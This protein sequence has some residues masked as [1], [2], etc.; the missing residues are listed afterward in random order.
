MGLVISLAVIIVLFMASLFQSTN[1]LDQTKYKIA[2]PRGASTYA[3]QKILQQKGILKPVS[4]FSFAA[5]I[6]S[7]S[8]GIQAGDYL[9]S[10]SDNLFTILMKL[11]R[12]EVVPS[13]QVEVTFPEGASIYRMGEVLKKQG[14]SDPKKFKGLVKEGITEPIREKYWHIFKYIP[15]ESL[16]GYLYPDTYMFFSSAK[17]ED[18]VIRMLDRFDAVVM[19]YWSK[20]KKDTKYNLHEILTLASIIEKEAANPAERPIISSVFHNRLDIKM[21]LDSCATIKYAL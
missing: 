21:A 3:V 6:L 9:F 4:S 14:V 8:R 1:P 13:E 17:A 20:V 2:I 18:L 5:R 15:S 12:G 7:L 11:K 16:E 19:P 10:P